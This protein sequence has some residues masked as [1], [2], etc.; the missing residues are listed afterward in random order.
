MTFPLFFSDLDPKEHREVLRIIIK[1]PNLIGL[2]YFKSKIG[3]SL[4]VGCLGD[5]VP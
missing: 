5:F 2:A 1:V 4:D 3:Q